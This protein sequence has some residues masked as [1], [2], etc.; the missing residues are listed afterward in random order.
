ML[1]RFEESLKLSRTAQA[2]NVMWRS[3]WKSLKIFSRSVG[4]IFRNENAGDWTKAPRRFPFI[5]R[6]WWRK[7]WMW[8]TLLWFSISLEHDLNLKTFLGVDTGLKFFNCELFRIVARLRKHWKLFFSLPSLFR[9]CCLKFQ[10]F[11]R[12]FPLALNKNN[13]RKLR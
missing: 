9:V 8:F 11:V 10:V 6:R 5:I 12:V 13:V 2:C 1:I 4:G 3:S 7:S